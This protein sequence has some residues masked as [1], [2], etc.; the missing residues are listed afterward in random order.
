MTDEELAQRAA[1][2]AT[3]W[4]SATIPL[5]QTQGWQLVALQHAGSGHQEMRVWEVVETWARQLAAV[6][7]TADDSDEG[8]DRVARARS[9]AES[10]M[11][12]MVLAGIRGAELFNSE[13]EE[14]RRVDPRARLREFISRNRVS[15]PRPWP[16]YAGRRY[17]GKPP[18]CR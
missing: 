8:R 10:R 14:P 11:R 4:I 3:S 16:E 7:A 18:G 5:S 6:L 1:E 17:R 15:P 2:L 12:D 9:E 13:R